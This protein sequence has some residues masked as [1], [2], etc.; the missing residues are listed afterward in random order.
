MTFIPYRLAMDIWGLCHYLVTTDRNL[1]PVVLHNLLL[2]CHD[3]LNVPTSVEE[4]AGEK[5]GV[6][7]GEIDGETADKRCYINKFS[8]SSGFY[9]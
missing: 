8:E 9:D 6:W 1:E 5:V 4:A 7:M 3:I 2:P